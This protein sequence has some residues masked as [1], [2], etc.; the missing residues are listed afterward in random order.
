MKVTNEA[1]WVPG[2]RIN[3]QGIL[4][5]YGRIKSDWGGGCVF[6]VCLVVFALFCFVASS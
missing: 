3:L 6:V 5:E 4:F 2:E 1:E